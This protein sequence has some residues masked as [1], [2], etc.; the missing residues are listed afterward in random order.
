MR[1]IIGALLVFLGVSVQAQTIPNGPHI[2]VNGHAERSVKPD[3]FILPMAISTISKDPSTAEQI[4]KQTLEMVAKLKQL[5]VMD[6]DIKVDNLAIGKEY[7]D[8]DRFVGNNY[9]RSFR[10]NFYDKQKLIGF[11]SSINDIKNL[12]IESIE[13][14]IKDIE[15]LKIDL[16]KD[17]VENSKRRAESL[18]SMYGM[19]V[20]GVYT[21]STAHISGDDNY[22]GPRE[23]SK[24][25]VTGVRR[26]GSNTLPPIEQILQE[27]EID[28]EEDIYAV[29][30]I[31]K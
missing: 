2:V 7:D 16:M 25:L 29:F 30:L 11:L 8:G 5:G 10:V 9:S 12:E 22:N 18:A 28:V 1:L 3:K 17:A 20:L 14:N 21:I 26:K 31:G 15:F 19:K 24:V 27:G 13:R 6:E 23:L 4:E